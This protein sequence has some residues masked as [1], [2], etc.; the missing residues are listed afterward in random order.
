MARGGFTAGL[1][2][3]PANAADDFKLE[4]VTS[5]ASIPVSQ[6]KPRIIVFSETR[7]GEKA[8][9][10]CR[11]DPV[12]RMA[13]R[14]AGAAAL[15]RHAAGFPRAAAEGR[16]HREAFDVCR[17]GALSPPEAGAGLRPQALCEHRFSR[18]A[19]SGGEAH[20]RSRS[21]DMRSRTRMRCRPICGRWAANGA[22]T[23]PAASSRAIASRAGFRPAFFW[24]T[25]CATRPRSRSRI[26]SNSRAKS[27]CRRR[28]TP[29]FVDLRTLTG[30]DAPVSGVFEQTIF[31]VNQVIHSGKILAVM[32]QHPTDP[33]ASIAT[34][35]V[36]LTIRSDV[37]NKQRNFSN[38]PILRNLVPVQLLMGRSSF[39][40]GDSISAGLPNLCARPDQGDCG[41]D[42]EGIGPF[43]PFSRAAPPRLSRYRFSSSASSPRKRALLR[44]RR[45]QA[46]RAARAA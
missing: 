21:S 44:P 12:R 23:P 34:I 19:R 16:R 41:G 13:A 35:Y 8:E 36:A 39:N 28:S 9:F 3:L 17:G 26:S 45:P 42:G 46:P 15:S 11:T 22:R 40:S 43:R 1:A 32:Q 29:Q 24:S 7:L 33:N 10:A 20:S 27:G 25:S 18:R 31:W 30:L 4:P 37:L 38:A 14:Q 5:V 2:P 6:L